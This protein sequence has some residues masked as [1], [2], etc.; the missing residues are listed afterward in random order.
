MIGSLLRFLFGTSNTKPLVHS[1]PRILPMEENA[2]KHL[3]T[4]SPSNVVAPVVAKAAVAAKRPRKPSERGQKTSA[5]IPTQL[6]HSSPQK[7]LSAPK[8]SVPSVSRKAVA[9]PK[10]KVE[11][12]SSMGDASDIVFAAAVLSF[13]T[14]NVSLPD[15]SGGGGSFGGGGAN[16]SWSDSSSSDSNDAGNY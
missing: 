6:K 16:S 9:E 15:F 1:A 14:D 2:F 7:L 12:S 10:K 13:D 11:E 4:E 8:A 3:V 5:I